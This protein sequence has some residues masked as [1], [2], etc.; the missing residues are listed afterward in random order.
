MK[1]SILFLLLTFGI[2]A[3]IAQ[4]RVVGYYPSWS[5]YS[6]P[7]TSVPFGNLTDIVH[8]FIFPYA[9]GSLDLNG[10]TEYPELI[11]AAH[12]NNVAVVIGVGGW[13]AARTPRFGQMAADT[14]ARKKFVSSLVQFVLTNGYDGVD[15]DWEYPKTAA[16]R[17]NLALLVRELRVALDAAGNNMTL[18]MAGPSTGWSGQWFD[19]ATMKDDFDWIGIMTYDYHGAWTAKAGP[20]SALYGNFSINTEGWVDYSY[21]Y[22]LTT[23]G[24]PKEKLLIGIPFYG[25]VFNASSLY[26]ASSGATQKTF[27]FIAPNVGSGWTRYWD[28]EGQVPYLINS[29]GTQLISYDDSQSVALKCAYV[30]AKGNGGVIIWALGQDLVQG[31]TPLLEVI[32]AALRKPASAAKQPQQAAPFLFSLEQNFPNPF[33]GETVVRYSIARP[34]RVT[35]RLYNSL[36]QCVK[37][38]SD[39]ERTAGSYDVKISS[40][41]LPSG[42][43]VYRMTAGSATAAKTMIVLR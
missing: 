16:E 12:S 6:T 35:L 17:S 5:K 3:G 30:N 28:A 40:D 19:F 11:N 7:H 27:T 34:A 13:D 14:T 21:G 25:Q 32:G 8:A 43:Y 23:R 36:G 33:N 38:L 1:L 22:Y 2:S 26:G 18:S 4:K 41:D 24:I 9:D 29:A 15:L 31:K 37:V 39:S 20:N 10:F 42:V